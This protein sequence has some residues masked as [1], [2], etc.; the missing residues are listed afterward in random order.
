M[1]EEAKQLIQAHAEL[2]EAYTH[3][4]EESEQKVR[5]IEEL[6][7]LPMSALLRIEELE[8]WLAK[9]SHNSSKPPS[10]DGF[11]RKRKRRPKSNKPKGGQAAHPGHTLQQVAVPDQVVTHRPTHCETCQRELPATA[12]RMIERRQIHELP[13]V[14]VQVTE[15]RV[16]ATPCPACG[17]V[18]VAKFPKGLD[19]PVQY[20]SRLRAVA[21]YL[22]QFQLLP[23]ERIREPGADLWGGALSDGTVASW[24][25]EAARRL[26]PTMQVLKERL[27]ASRPTH[28]DET[29]V[30]IKGLVHL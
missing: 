28:V 22:S 27:V 23:V 8:R 2:K 3:L 10:S 25:A 14:R 19:A 7:G 30:K 1:T 21:V 4:K 11:S 5:R 9:D 26:E 16:E 13:E 20:G 18:T 24:I 29:G 17:H 12:G 15:H 6:E